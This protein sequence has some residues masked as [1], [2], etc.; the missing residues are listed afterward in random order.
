LEAGGLQAVQALKT[1]NPD[2]TSEEL[3]QAYSYLFTEWQQA[4][5]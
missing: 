3:E 5:E 2:A 4:F 1:L